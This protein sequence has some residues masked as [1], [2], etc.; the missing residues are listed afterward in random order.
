MIHELRVVYVL[1]RFPFLTETF[2]A[3]E[4]RSLREQ[5]VNVKIVS[6][7][8]PGDGPVQ[9]VSAQLLPY[10]QYTLGLT[11]PVLWYAQLYYLLFA[12]RSYL[13][14]LF[15][16]F[17]VHGTFSPL[18]ILKRLTIFLK[19]VSVSY[20]LRNE[21]IALFH[22][23]F[24]WLSGVGAWICATLLNKPFTVTT[25]AYDL[26]ASKD[27]LALVVEKADHVI[28]ISQY[29]KFH[30]A[31]SKICP[32]SKISVVHCGINLEQFVAVVDEE[33]LHDVPLD[34]ESQP[35]RIISVG[36]LNYKKG[37]EYLI[38]ACHYLK[39]QDLHFVCTIVGR[40]KEEQNLR[41]LIEQFH[42]QN[43]VKLLG[44]LA[45]NEVIALYREHDVFVLAAVIA[46]N[47]DRDGIPVV[48]LEAG[49]Q[50]LP[51]I[52]TEVSGIPEVAQSD[53]T[54]VLVPSKDVTALAEA[55][56]YLAAN[57]AL[58]RQLG[59]NA[60]ALVHAE[61]NISRCTH[62][63]VTIFQNAVNETIADSSALLNRSYGC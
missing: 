23:H 37:H 43:E 11:S 22:A 13:S 1:L 32:A 30:L 54:G 36:T 40:G 51:L 5:G 63:L 2:I 57:R 62:H 27:L 9:P 50:G 42:L 44:A 17:F 47:G 20:Q 41:D 15:T 16:L 56:L 8:E 3:E 12:N 35:L 49:A 25:H 26:Y 34:E 21:S 55:V 4:I 29:N 45:N 19:A 14:L 6:L 61:F 52:S 7:L 39:E 18:L 28:T 33:T 48:M 46:P 53:Y 58:R 59:K 60:Q 31:D 10:C 24:A 38:R